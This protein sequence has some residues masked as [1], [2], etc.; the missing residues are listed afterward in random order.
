MKLNDGERLITVMLAEVMEALKL[1]NE[2]DPKLVKSLAYDGDD[3]AIARKYPHL[4]RDETPVPPFVKETGDILWMWGIIDHGISKLTGAEADE[5]K[6][7]HYNKFHGFDAN[8]D[9]HYHIAHT[10]IEDLGE[11]AGQKALNSHNRSS[12]PRYQAMYEKFEGYINRHE[13]N[14]LSF[15]ALRDLCS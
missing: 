12:L 3:W 14:P 11:F 7:W 2:M 10:M 5:A 4:F 13:A 6:G 15:E 1:N 8:N 9:K